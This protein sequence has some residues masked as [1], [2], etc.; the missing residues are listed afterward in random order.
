MCSAE[1]CDRGPAEDVL[2]RRVGALAVASVLV[3]GVA[4]GAPAWLSEVP[5][6]SAVDAMAPP[7]GARGSPSA[8]GPPR[9][10]SGEA[11]S[12]GREA[13]AVVDAQRAALESDGG[14]S[15]S[16][17]AA[18]ATATVRMSV[19]VARTDGTF[20]ARDDDTDPPVFGDLDVELFGAAAPAAGWE[21]GEL[22]S[23]FS[24]AS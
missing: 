6:E 4:R 19:R 9:D 7:S 17:S 20:S 12:S 13:K 22:F 3:P 1:S 21:K 14:A 2:R 11:R 18:T 24:R 10:R 23:P 15:L 8:S 16:R 5:T